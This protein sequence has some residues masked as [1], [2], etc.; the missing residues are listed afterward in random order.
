MNVLRIIEHSSLNQTDLDLIIDIKSISWPYSYE[1]QL[2]W[3]NQ[4]LSNEDLHLIFYF[5]G[6]AVGYLNLTK[7]KVLLNNEIVSAYGVGNV[8]TKVY[9]C[10]YGKDLLLNTNQFLLEQNKVGLLFC[11]D[12]LIPFYSKCGWA[13]VPVESVSLNFDNSK[14]KTMVFNFQ[15][16]LEKLC[17]EGK[18]F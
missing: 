11:K 2:K 8:C 16:K 5:D 18:P 14:I 3:I 6:N 17:Y 13:L 4:N 12:N 9:G 1:D 7:I 10:G 15:E